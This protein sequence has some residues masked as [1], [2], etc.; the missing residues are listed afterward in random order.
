MGDNTYS[1]FV[2]ILKLIYWHGSLMGTENLPA[3]GPAVVV[4]NH[5]GPDG[6]IGVA[7]SIPLR[8]HPWIVSEMVDRQKAPDYLRVDFVESSL[9]LKPP[10]SVLF[11]RALSRITVP[12][13]TSL[14]CIPVTRGEGHELTLSVEVLKAGRVVLV[15]PEAPELDL[16]PCTQMRPFLKGFTRLGELFYAETG[17]QLHFYPVA[18]HGSKRVRIGKAVIFDPDKPHSVERRR[19]K[20]LLERRVREMY[21]ELDRQYS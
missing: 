21:L 1:F 2:R 6:P 7:C 5:H 3:Q 12:L 17:Q 20:H 11:A 18:V 19:L 13:L 15:F 16:D 8:M 10:L 4:A 9:K 14:G